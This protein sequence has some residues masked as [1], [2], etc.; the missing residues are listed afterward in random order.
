M[1]VDEGSEMRAT[2]L[3]INGHKLGMKQSQRCMWGQG[4]AGWL[5]PRL[6]VRAKNMGNAIKRKEVKVW[7]YETVT[8]KE[9]E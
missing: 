4:S 5:R 8:W 3:K 6:D 9:G 7:K 1:H 2:T